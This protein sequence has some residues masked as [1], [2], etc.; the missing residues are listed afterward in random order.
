MRTASRTHA[1]GALTHVLYRHV[2][3]VLK[4]ERGQARPRILHRYLQQL[5]RWG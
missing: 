5:G 4:L 2:E 3:H 1:A